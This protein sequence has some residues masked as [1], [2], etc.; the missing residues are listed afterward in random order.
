MEQSSGEEYAPPAAYSRPAPKRSRS[1]SSQGRGRGRGRRSA[2]DPAVD[3][4]EEDL[5]RV[6]HLRMQRVNFERVSPFKST[7]YQ[8]SPR[9]YCTM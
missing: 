4:A 3:L 5:A 8:H 1:S 9:V 7:A 6:Q 2:R